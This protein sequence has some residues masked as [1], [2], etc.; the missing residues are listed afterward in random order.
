VEVLADAGEVE[1][2]GDAVLAQVRARADAREQEQLRRVQRP[3]RE[4]HLARRAR[5]VEPLLA[6]ELDADGTPAFEEDARRM[7]PGEDREVGAAPRRPEVGRGRALAPPAPGRHVGRAEAGAQPAVRVVVVRVARLL[8]RL[9]EGARERVLDTRSPHAE[10]A[11]AAVVRARAEL[12][13]LGAL[14]VGQDLGEGPARVAE[15]RPLVVVAARPAAVDHAVGRARAAE[16]LPAREVEH[17]ALQVLLRQR[18]VAPVE[19][20]RDHDREQ[21]PGRTDQRAPVAAARLEQEHPQR[22]IGAEALA[23]HAARRAGTDDH[24]VVLDVAHGRSSQGSPSC[25][26]VGAAADAVGCVRCRAL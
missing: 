23:Q 1:H 13:R 24:V 10:R 8:P 17:A 9:D 5:P 25:R 11:A 19:G 22:R 26:P 4:D 20:A 16:H 12:V 2:R 14:E 7:R 3:R 6:R 21:T 15:P 18:L